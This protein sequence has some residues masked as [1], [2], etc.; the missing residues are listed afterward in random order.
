M[1]SRLRQHIYLDPQ[2]GPW[3]MTSKNKFETK[4]VF[5][6]RYKGLVSSVLQV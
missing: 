4:Q 2:N 3:M 6:Q 5:R 1:H